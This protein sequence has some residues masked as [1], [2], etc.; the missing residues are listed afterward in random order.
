MQ[1]F[2]CTHP[3]KA[4]RKEHP[5]Q[6]TADVK[7]ASA[8]HPRSSVIFNCC[9]SN[10]FVLRGCTRLCSRSN[11]SGLQSVVC[12]TVTSCGE[13]TSTDLCQILFVNTFS[14][15]QSLDSHINDTLIRTRVLD[16]QPFS[17]V[18]PV[19]LWAPPASSAG[20]F[21]SHLKLVI[22]LRLHSLFKQQAHSSAPL[23]GTLSLWQVFDA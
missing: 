9:S 10:K 4:L 21:F 3:L 13:R 6:G 16:W 12:C 15:R 17:S 18:W 19:M 23:P 1:S 22:D 2:G 7:Q 20:A 11:N 8:L 14:V 5:M